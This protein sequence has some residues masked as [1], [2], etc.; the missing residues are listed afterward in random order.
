MEKRWRWSLAV[1][2]ALVLAGLV[3][4]QLRRDLPLDQ[5]RARWGAP[6][7]QFIDVDGVSVHYRGEG[8]GPVLL[9]LHGNGASLHTWEGWASALEDRFRVVR[10]DLPGF[11]LTG[12]HPRGDYRT[13]AYLDLLARFIDKLQLK[14]LVIGGNSMGGG[15]AWLYAVAHPDQVSALVLVDAAGY[16]RPDAKPPL[17]FRLARLPLVS[18]LLAH[19]DPERLVADGLHKMYGDPTR[20]TPELVERYVQLALRPG[21][22]QAFAARNRVAQVDHSADVRQL[23]LPTLILWGAHDQTIPL[24]AAH[25][26]A[27]DIAGSQLIVYPELGH[28]PM[29]EEP[30]ETAADVRRFL[31]GALKLPARVEAARA[32]Q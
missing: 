11:G 8:S 22:R 13:E 1:L 32:P 25:R 17:V 19:F 30:I 28:I 15:L 29:E 4:S 16:P 18:T 5:L 21:N 12:P 27:A 10:I 23:K 14:P 24:S 26:F 2:L 20:V 31:V 3:A 6:P 7:S 9:L